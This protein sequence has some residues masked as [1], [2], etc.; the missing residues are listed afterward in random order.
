MSRVLSNDIEVL[1]FLRG[2]E[3]GEEI[4]KGKDG[5]GFYR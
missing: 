4:R 3:P 1:I 5:E 2:S